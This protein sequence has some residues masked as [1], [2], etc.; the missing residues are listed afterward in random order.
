MIKK[1]PFH[2]ILIP[3]YFVVALYNQNIAEVFPQDI[4]RPLIVVILISLVLFLL[5]YL[6]IHDVK[7]AALSASTI[8][9]FFF[10][11]G[12]VYGALKIGST[13]ITSL[14]R[15]RILLPLFLMLIGISV[16]KIIKIK[17]DTGIYTQ[18]FNLFGIVLLFL[19]TIN[20]V[21]INHAQSEAKAVN[22]IPQAVSM[23]GG[24]TA[25]QPDIYYIIADAYGRADYLL[26]EYDFDNSAFLNWLDEKGFYV[27]DCGRSNYAHTVLSLSSTFEMNYIPAYASV[28]QYYDGGLDDYVVHNRV[29]EE[30]VNRG[31]Q[32]VTFENVHWDY[33]DADIFYDFEFDIF[34][35]YLRP[36]E[37][38]LMM[39]SMFR[40]VIEFNDTT[41]DYFAALTST[42]VKE[43]YAR[44]KFIL[45]TLEN[46]VIAVEGPKFVFAHVE[47]PHGPYVFDEDGTFLEEDAFYRG[48]YYSAIN[49]MY[50]DLGYIKQIQFMNGRLETIVENILQQSAVPP[51]IIIQGDHSIEEFGDAEDRMKVLYAVYY[52]DGDYADFY[53]HI[54][55]INTFR[56][57]FN[58]VYGTTYP[59]LEDHSFYSARTDRFDWYEIIDS[60]PVCQ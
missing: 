57:V 24:Q 9:F 19:P 14:A 29:R 50:G 8:L 17:G 30:L 37:N 32:I 4:V 26:D 18:L 7:R 13:G 59:L 47:T 11:Y 25:Q 54:T 1:V 22:E 10:L 52:P 55:P 60:S 39:N 5:I 21:W 12:L 2:L 28:D 44:Q 6:F 46:E 36:F 43:H 45:D 33:E 48:E 38:M 42:P 56:N 51:I 58:H 34:S 41:Q 40:A 27:A 16:W 20:I 15:H 49:D 53:E 35:P 23:S 3:A 31:Y